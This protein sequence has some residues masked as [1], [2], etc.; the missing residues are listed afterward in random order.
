MEKIQI[1]SRNENQ[2]KNSERFEQF[3]KQVE[4]IST[5]TNDVKEK[6]GVKDSTMHSFSPD[7]LPTH[8]LTMTLSQKVF[9][10]YQRILSQTNDDEK[11]HNFIWLGKKASRNG[12][13]YYSIEKALI[14][15]ENIEDLRQSEASPGP[16]FNIYDDSSLHDEY[17]VIVD[18]HS[19]PEQSPDYADFDKMPPALLEELSLKKPGENFSIGDL[20]YYATLLSISN[21]SKNI[22]DK[23]IIGA[24]ITYAGN[25]LNIALDRDNPAAPL[26]TIRQL[27]AITQNQVLDLPTS[28]FN[29]EKSE[30]F[31]DVSKND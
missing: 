10:D 6:Y 1:I 9:E 26:T 4:R 30:Q 19:H 20:N 23:T 12:Q 13:E 16:K 15:P 17:D 5:K 11:E 18:G 22:K 24:V 29:K 27:G 21:T 2:E 31:F 3:S 7:L 14:V 28:K 8:E 25:L